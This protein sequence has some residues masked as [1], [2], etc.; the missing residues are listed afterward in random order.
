MK[1]QLKC[2]YTLKRQKIKVV[3]KNEKQLPGKKEKNKNP[4][5]VFFRNYHN[6][7]YRGLA[8]KKKVLKRKFFY[9]LTLSNFLCIIVLLILAGISIIMITGNN[10]I[11]NKTIVAKEET[12]EATKIEL[13]KM[14]VAE[15]Q[16]GEN[17]YQ[18]LKQS[19]LQEAM[20]NQFGE[21]I[22]T[23]IDNKDTTFTVLFNNSNLMYDIK[24]N[25][26]IEE[27]LATTLLGQVKSG[28]VKMGTYIEYTPDIVNSTDSEYLNLMSDLENYSGSSD[29]NVDTLMQETTLKWRI[30]DVKEGKVRLISDTPTTSKISLYG[31]QGYN[32]GVY[33]LDETCNTLYNNTVYANKVQN[34]KIE[35]IENHLEYDYSENETIQVGNTI[36]Y[37]TI[38]IYRESG[39]KYYPSIFQDEKDVK[40]DDEYTK[41]ILNKSEQTTL[42]DE[43][44]NEAKD[45]I[46]IRHTHWYKEMTKDDFDNQ[47]YYEIFIKKD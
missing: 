4:Y 26:Q 13:I 31:Q 21:S 39:Y 44:V 35:D 43:V 40:I 32:N 12:E 6:Y 47:I 30:L 10:G 28:K 2:Y 45:S 20:N 11:L 41:G 37:G 1:N 34:L 22:A 5:S 23:V 25:G 42:I 19:N 3:E 46:S 33:L 24:E 38:N 17:G 29:N 27:Q 15:A 18:E 16:I 8:R 7:N 9:W 14:A 36:K